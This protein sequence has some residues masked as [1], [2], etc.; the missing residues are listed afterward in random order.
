MWDY[1]AIE[2]NFSIYVAQLVEH[3]TSNGSDKG[4][5]PMKLAYW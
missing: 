1:I 2:V 4:F 3:S 5:I